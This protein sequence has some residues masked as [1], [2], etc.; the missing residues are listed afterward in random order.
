MKRTLM[1]IVLGL[2][3]AAA[4]FPVLVYARGCYAML[5][6]V[7]PETGEQVNCQLISEGYPCRY[8]CPFGD[9]EP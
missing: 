8:R 1:S 4:V 2:V 5:M 3:L 7:D 9:I 6:A